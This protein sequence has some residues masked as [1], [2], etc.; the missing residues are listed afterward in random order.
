[1]GVVVY[2]AGG[3]LKDTTRVAVGGVVYYCRTFVEGHN[4][5][6]WWCGVLFAGRLKDTTTTRVAVGGV[7]V[8]YQDV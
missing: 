7:V 3:L 1:M 6:S 5:S 4:K 2:Y 8:V